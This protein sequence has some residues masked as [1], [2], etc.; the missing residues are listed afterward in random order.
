MNTWLQTG[1]LIKWVGLILAGM[2]IFFSQS[3]RCD[4]PV[5]EFT[6]SATKRELAMRFVAAST[7]LR[8]HYRR[9]DSANDRIAWSGFFIKT[10]NQ[11][12]E[13]VLLVESPTVELNAARRDTH[14]GDHPSG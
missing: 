10:Y 8:D 2:L 1:A 11:C 7:A 14:Q 13:I 12:T 4:F 6:D 9:H 5:P 3:A